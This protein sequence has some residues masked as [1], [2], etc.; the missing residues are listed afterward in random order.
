MKQQSNFSQRISLISSRIIKTKKVKNRLKK[1]R[2]EEEEK[3][4]SKL[5]KNLKLFHR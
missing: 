3:E 4:N 1:I 2:K 5:K